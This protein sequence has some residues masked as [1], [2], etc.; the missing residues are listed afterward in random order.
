MRLQ[1]SAILT[2]ILALD[3]IFTAGCFDNSN[4]TFQGYVKGEYIYVAAPL[5]GTLTNFAVAS[6]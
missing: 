3:V 1:N 2:G 4:G 5:G 6:G